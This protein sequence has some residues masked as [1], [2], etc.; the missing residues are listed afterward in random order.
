[1]GG[2]APPLD[3]LP[4]APQVVVPAPE[5]EAAQPPPSIPDPPRNSRKIVLIAV[6]AAPLLFGSGWFLGRVTVPAPAPAPVEVS[7]KRRPNVAVPAATATAA[8]APGPNSTTIANAA[9]FV[10][11]PSPVTESPVVARMPA[12]ASA[13]ASAPAVAPTLVSEPPAATPDGAP[14]PKPEASNSPNP[15]PSL[16][17]S[18]T[19][20][21]SVGEKTAVPLPVP[22]RPVPVPTPAQPAP[23]IGPTLDPVAWASPNPMPSSS[24]APSPAR[25]T[26]FREQ[27]APAEQ[28]ERGPIDGEQ[29]R[30]DDEALRA[31][32]LGQVAA[33]DM[34]L[35]KGKRMQATDF[36][37]A[38]ITTAERYAARRSDDV[39]SLTE[40]AKLCRKLGALQL[41]TASVGEA[42]ATF[43]RGRKF[44]ELLKSSAQL[45]PA[46]AQ[47]LQELETGLQTLPRD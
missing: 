42:R 20:I 41:Q 39:N 23:A 33:A 24:P 30:R 9:E 12:P 11:L 7:H 31:Q 17:R 10:A 45:T 18:A 8:P 2:L 36:Y 28:T 22:S 40:M 14:P 44:L 38:A 4:P 13:A 35:R 34:A 1:M 25:P 27:N 15:E 3:L 26:I 32:W 47:I 37:S 46:H 29:R 6:A 5:P 21:A 16:N 43:E 19:P